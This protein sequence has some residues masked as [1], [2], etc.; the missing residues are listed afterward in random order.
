MGVAYIADAGAIEGRGED[1]YP[2][3]NST[4]SVPWILRRYGRRSVSWFLCGSAESGARKSSFFLISYA[5][6]L[7]EADQ[8]FYFGN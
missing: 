4:G 3:V 7:I 6:E 8:V 2:K 1:A 5:V